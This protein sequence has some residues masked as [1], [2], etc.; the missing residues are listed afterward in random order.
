MSLVLS[1]VISI[2][3]FI[4]QINAKKILKA[5][6][7]YYRIDSWIPDCGSISLSIS[8][9]PILSVLVLLQSKTDQAVHLL[10]SSFSVPSL[11]VARRPSPGRD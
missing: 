2:V 6:L 7:C 10:L 9:I 4:F 11:D 8:W 3:V 5:F 1:C